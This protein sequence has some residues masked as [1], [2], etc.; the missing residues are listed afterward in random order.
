[1][2]NTGLLAIWQLLCTGLFNSGQG[3]REFCIDW[4]IDRK[5][6]E[7]YRP[8]GLVFDIYENDGGIFFKINT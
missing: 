5:A 8:T 6:V 4:M 7:L 2:F 1:M 3:K